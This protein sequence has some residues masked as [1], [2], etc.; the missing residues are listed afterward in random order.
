MCG[1]CVCVHALTCML[2]HFSHVKVFVPLWTVALQTLLLSMGFS[3]Q[4]YWSG[5]PCPP[6]GDLPNPGTEPTFPMA[7]ALQADSL[8]LRHHRR[9]CVC[10]CVYTYTYIH[11]LL[12]ILL[13]Y[14]SLLLLLF[15]LSVTSDSLQYH[16]LQHTRI[17][18]PSPCPNV[19]SNSCPLSRRC[20]PTISSSVNPFSS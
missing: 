7:P 18:C 1:V 13:P 15:S 6:P 4:E 11:I 19:C 3:R 20:H 2:N 12:Q 16:G 14:R 10:V 17:P 5:L 8:A 9:V